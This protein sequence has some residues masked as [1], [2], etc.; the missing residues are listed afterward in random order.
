MF[1]SVLWEGGLI[2]LYKTT[3]VEDDNSVSTIFQMLRNKKCQR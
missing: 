1:W 3:L 2:E